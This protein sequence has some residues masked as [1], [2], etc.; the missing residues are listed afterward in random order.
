M[1]KPSAG[2]SDGNLLWVVILLTVAAGAT[3]FSSA[4]IA[5]FVLDN[6]HNSEALAL[7]IVD[8][9]SIK[10]DSQV[11]ERNL[12]SATL[13]LRSIQDIGLAL[14]FGCVAVALSVSV[15]IW[16]RGKG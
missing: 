13:A 3:A 16:R 8:G 9:T 14:S 1:A 7:I 15:R 4:Y 2:G 6:L 12:S 11:L 5:G 10:S